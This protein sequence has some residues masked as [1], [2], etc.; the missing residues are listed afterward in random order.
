MYSY[1]KKIIKKLPFS[2]STR[3]LLRR[4]IK[5]AAFYFCRSTT[6][7]LS[8]YYGFDRGVPID[9]FYIENFL[10]QNQKDI[11]GTCL[12]LLNNNYT[13][14]YG[15]EKVVKSDVLDLDEK[16]KMANIFDDL[17]HLKKI[18]DNSY[19][20]IILTQVFQFIDNVDAGISECHRILKSGGVLLVT[21]PSISRIDCVSGVEGDYWRFTE[22][23]AKYLFEKKFSSKQLNISTYG[24]A[25]SGIY[26]YAGLAQEDTSSRILGKN[27][28]N[29]PLIITVKAVKP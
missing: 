27:D 16:N 15:K 18:A 8:N 2:E 10:K 25:R 9:R 28:P 5:P 13:T 4:I 24:N 7:P 12:E 3:K 19:D 20:C 21:L 1:L 14:T 26:F 6:G 23:S 17:R 11:H 22:A 29:F